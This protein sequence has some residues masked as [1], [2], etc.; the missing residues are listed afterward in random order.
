MTC[1]LCTFQVIYVG[2]FAPLILRWMRW[3]ETTNEF[4]VLQNTYFLFM[5]SDAFI[6]KFEPQTV[7]LMVK[8]TEYQE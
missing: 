3:L 8:D 7:D 1:L 6:L 5:Y 2:Y 4:L